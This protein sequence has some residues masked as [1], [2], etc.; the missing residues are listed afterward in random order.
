[1]AALKH[2]IPLSVPAYY[3]NRKGFYSINLQAI[4]SASRKFIW[5]SMATCGGTHDSLAWK[6]TTLSKK[7]ESLP[8]GMFIVGDD[9]YACTDK[10]ITPFSTQSTK[11]NKEKDNFNYY[12]SRSRINVE[13][14]FGML[15]QRFG[16]LRRAQ[17]H[18]LQHVTAVT[19][20][21]MALHNL[22]VD[23]GMTSWQ[24][25]IECDIAT[26]DIMRPI[27][28]D[29]CSYAPRD[30]HKKRQ[31]T[32]VRQRLCDIIKDK[33]LSRPNS[34]MQGKRKSRA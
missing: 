9:A 33:G 11:G 22:C 24:R 6:A 26:Q 19:V 14:A 34:S 10:L 29:K 18:S 12:Q 15:V 28:Q 3:F 2:L 7:I 5:Y 21:C 23:D 1:M 16:I 30:G 8:D 13:C 20:V 4:A 31:K 25:A 27:R 17:A 32:D